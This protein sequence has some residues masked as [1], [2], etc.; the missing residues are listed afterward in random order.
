MLKGTEEDEE[1]L[2]PGTLAASHEDS[3][4]GENEKDYEDDLEENSDDDS[5][6]GEDDESG[7]DEKPEPGRT[8]VVSKRPRKRTANTGTTKFEKLMK[9][10]KTIAQSQRNDARMV[11]LQQ[12]EKL[13]DLPTREVKRRKLLMKKP[14]G[15]MLHEEIGFD[16]V[17]A[18]DHRI[19][20]SGKEEFKIDRT[21][22]LSKTRFVPFGTPCF[23]KNTGDFYSNKTD[24]C[25][26]WC[27]EKF[28]TLPIPMPY[29]FRLQSRTDFVFHVNGQFCSPSCM[30]AKMRTTRRSLDIGRLMLKKVY[31]INIGIDIPL[32]PPLESLKKFGGKYTI[33]EFRA[34]GGSGIKTTL[35]MP[36]FI[37]FSA[38][39]TEIEKTETVVSEIGGKELARRR[40][41]VKTGGIHSVS[42]PFNNTR[43]DKQQHGKFASAPS[44]K[45]QINLS[46]QRLRLQR[47]DIGQ[48]KK[49]SDIMKF[50]KFKKKD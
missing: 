41:S 23:F 30:L 31:G 39:I 33:R 9:V 43:P 49:K 21:L 38:G 3:D 42:T 10:A 37:P 8:T 36:P 13:Q 50:M 34:T 4:D 22:F 28:N 45:E 29:R 12:K 44:I 35:I 40:I 48:T 19:K 15:D 17:D 18:M 7:G 5:C 26:L 16:D 2:Q 20:Q 47:N 25:C 14:V 11:R 6:F 32:A 46:D 27:T 24:L 1:Q